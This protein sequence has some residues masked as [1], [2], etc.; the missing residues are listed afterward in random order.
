MLRALWGT[1]NHVFGREK[2]SAKLHA[3]VFDLTRY[4][5]IRRLSPWQIGKALDH[6][7]GKTC[8][9]PQFRFAEQ[10]GG[11]DS[12]RMIEHLAPEAGIVNLKGFFNHVMGGDFDAAD[13]E[14]MQKFVKVL[15]KRKQWAE[16]HRNNPHLKKD[17][18]EK[19]KWAKTR[20]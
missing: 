7:K 14:S 2:A 19:E 9:P 20:N 13:P 12:R 18:R 10:N 6:L 17:Q 1:A 11:G 5:S 3:L 15:K 16:K 8:L 4:T